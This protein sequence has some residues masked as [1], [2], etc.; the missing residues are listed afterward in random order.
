[1][2]SMANDWPSAKPKLCLP[3]SSTSSLGRL[4][5]TGGGPS[6]R[7]S[8]RPARD[9]ARVRNSIAPPPL[10]LSA[11]RSGPPRERQLDHLKYACALV[12]AAA[13]QQARNPVIVGMPEQPRNLGAH[14]ARKP[15]EMLFR[16]QAPLE[17]AR[18]RALVDQQLA[19]EISLAQISPC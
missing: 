18:H 9:D 4:G 13:F 12:I 15:H 11:V 5:A 10:R 3:G 7:E 19:H 17:P 2:Y 6:G 16:R 14:Q 1:T 8:T